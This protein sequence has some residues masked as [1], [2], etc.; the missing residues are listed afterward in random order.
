MLTTR[1][2]HTIAEHH[3]RK[4]A[5]VMAHHPKPHRVGKRARV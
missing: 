1:E 5:P 4:L 3:H 2:R